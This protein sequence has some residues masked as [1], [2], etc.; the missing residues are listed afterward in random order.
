MLQELTLTED[1]V[2]RPEGIDRPLPQ[3]DAEMGAG[4]R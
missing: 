1:T 2:Q 3:E 4:S